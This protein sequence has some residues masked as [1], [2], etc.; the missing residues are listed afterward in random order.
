MKKA[1][2]IVF[3]VA[4]ASAGIFFGF[5]KHLLVRSYA[6]RIFP[7]DTILYISID[8]VERARK[9]LEGTDVWKHLNRSPRKDKYKKLFESGFNSI[10]SATGFDIRPVLEQFKG[11]V[12]IALFPLAE[13]KGSAGF[14]ARVKDEDDFKRFLEE[15]IDPALKRR[16]PDVKKGQDNADGITYY[17]YSSPHFPNDAS[18]SYFISGKH[19]VFS[20]NEA[21][22]RRMIS[23]DRRK[24]GALRESEVFRNAKREVHYERGA[25]LFLNVPA[26]LG[27]LE[28]S[29][30]VVGRKY[31][32]GV[33][34]VTGVE[35]VRGLIYTSRVEN[36]GFQESG[37][38]EVRSNRTGLLKIYMDQKPRKM[39]SLAYI[40]ASMKMVS[41]ASLPDFVKMWDELNSQLEKILDPEQYQKWQQGMALLRGLMNF[42]LKRDLMEPLGE[43]FAFSYEPGSARRPLDVNFLVVTR[44]RNPDAFKTT[45]ARLVALASMRGMVQRETNYH[46]RT[47]Q[48]LTLSMPDYTI[49]PSYAFED[50]WFVFAS[51]DALLQQAFD[52]KD[53]GDGIQSTADFKKCTSG[54]PNEIHAL[55]YTNVSAYLKAQAE[56]LRMNAD[57]ENMKWIQEYSI[58]QELLELSKVLS[59]N[60]TYSKI[61]KNGIRI[62]GNSSIPSAFLGF[63]GL[64]EYL[65]E[66]IK[67]YSKDSRL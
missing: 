33:L 43:E 44:L 32:P 42:D 21:G 46:G 7:D 10:E 47:I 58:D 54:F 25:L 62:K 2:A 63:T 48:I 51:R 67:R 38:V 1:I 24:S 28:K 9:N 59:G 4:L 57:E 53:S 66:M 6:E 52:A 34:K 22:I 14:V 12:A 27:L 65:P 55:S 26:G 50:K 15:Q 39:E 16:F 35:A 60:A 49:S 17:K 37:F 36:T 29:I 5:F 61:E 40:P 18:P 23:I 8:N 45:V 31:W 3:I 56:I 19:F 30:P 41:A 20:M 64:L 13:G 11:E